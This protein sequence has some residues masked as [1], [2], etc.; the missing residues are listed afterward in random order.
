ME[1]ITNIKRKMRTNELIITK[2]DKNYALIIL[3]RK[4]Y[5]RKTKAFIQGNQFATIKTTQFNA[6]KKK[7]NKP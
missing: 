3:T 4:T 5:K 7:L 2:V 6:T 1:I